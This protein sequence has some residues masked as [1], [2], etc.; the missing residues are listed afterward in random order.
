MR[1]EQIAQIYQ[2]VKFGLLQE[3]CYVMRITIWMLTENQKVYIIV[4]SVVITINDY[5]YNVIVI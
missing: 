3:E 1:M 5:I 4:R 2:N